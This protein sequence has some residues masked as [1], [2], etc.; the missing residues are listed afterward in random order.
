VT[1]T[2]GCW[3]TAAGAGARRGRHRRPGCW[4]ASGSP[5]R[6]GWEAWSPRWRTERPGGAVDHIAGCRSTPA[7]DVDGLT[8]ILLTRVLAGH[9]RAGRSPAWGREP[10]HGRGPGRRSTPAWSRVGLLG[11]G[12][13]GGESRPVV[14]PVG[15]F[16]DP[17]AWLRTRSGSA[18]GRR[19]PCSRRW[20]RSS[21]RPAAAGVHRLADP[22]GAH[23][24]VCRGRRPARGRGRALALGASIDGRDTRDA[25][26]PRGGLDVGRRRGPAPS[27]AATATVDDTG[28]ALRVAP[29]LSP[30][31]TL[32]A[33][34]G[35]AGGADHA[36]SQRAPASGRRSEPPRAR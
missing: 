12:E 3:C 19:S 23:D 9:A 14:L 8:G 22:A 25:A 33:G 16:T 15:L 2:A 11:P 18:G 35:R 26:G 29:A 34:A 27:I 31:V 30:P 21:C 4:A 24:H 32:V 13:R 1:L 10:G 28:L 36:P 20:R 5:P 6:P 7:P 17:G